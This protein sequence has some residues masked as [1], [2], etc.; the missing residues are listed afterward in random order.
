MKDELG[1]KII[2]EFIGLRE[3]TYSYSRGNNSENKKVKDRKKC[4][5]KENLNLKTIKIA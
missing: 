5:I 4:I 2:R 1:G 3:K